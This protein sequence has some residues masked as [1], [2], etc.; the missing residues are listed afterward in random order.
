MSGEGEERECELGGLGERV[1]EERVRGKI[2]NYQ[3]LI[4]K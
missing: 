4:I 1:S 2:Q 3:F